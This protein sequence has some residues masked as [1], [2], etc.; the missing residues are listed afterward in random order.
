MK[1]RRKRIIKF[2][3][4]SYV[5]FWCNICEI[6]A[7]KEQWANGIHKK[8]MCDKYKSNLEIRRKAEGRVLKAIN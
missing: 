4:N 8:K 6:D 2:G 3:E 7:P 1:H 5:Y